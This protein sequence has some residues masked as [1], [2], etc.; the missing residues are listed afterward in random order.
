MTVH[1][2]WTHVYST[3]WTQSTVAFSALALGFDIVFNY[4]L[5]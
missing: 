1:G 3:A 5:G 2:S 4:C